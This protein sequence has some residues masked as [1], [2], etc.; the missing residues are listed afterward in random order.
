MV[1][2]EVATLL[3]VID[4]PTTVGRFAWIV[5]AE[6][7]TCVE[8]RI[9]LLAKGSRFW[10]ETD[11]AHAE[12]YFLIFLRHGFDDGSGAVIERLSIGR[13]GWPSLPITGRR[14]LGCG[15][16]SVAC[17]VEN[18]SIRTSVE[19]LDALAMMHEERLRYAIG[20]EGDVFGIRMPGRVG[21]TLDSVGKLRVEFL[22][23]SALDQYG[24]TMIAAQMEAHLLR[25]LTLE[26]VT[27][28]AVVFRL[29][30]LHDGCLVESFEATLIDAH[31]IP[32]SIAGWD[33]AIGKI[34]VDAVG[35]DMH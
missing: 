24:T 16:N 2:G 20:R 10:V 27:V 11:G 31:G 29:T 34:G 15:D 9:N 3:L 35:C 22:Y 23:T 6:A 19:D 25:V 28:H 13:K 32:Q 8:Q 18:Y 17:N 21:D 7:I 30:I 14:K 1:D 33:E 26:R 5:E 12:M 4:E